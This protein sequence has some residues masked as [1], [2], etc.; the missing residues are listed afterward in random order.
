[1][2]NRTT[3]MPCPG[4]VATRPLTWA[5]TA[6]TITGRRLHAAL[7]VMS[8]PLDWN[9]TA[10]HWGLGRVYHDRRFGAA[11]EGPLPP[12]SEELP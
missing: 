11:V 4:R 8:A 2:P 1:M 12:A 5:R 6:C 3:H 10:T 9:V 7:D